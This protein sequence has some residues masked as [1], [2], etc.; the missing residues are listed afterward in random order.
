MAKGA[1]E[2]RLFKGSNYFKYFHQWVAIIR[3]RLLL[4][5]RLLFEEIR[6]VDGPI[7]S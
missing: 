3:G 2:G 1:R 5:G 4:E 7:M 6:Y